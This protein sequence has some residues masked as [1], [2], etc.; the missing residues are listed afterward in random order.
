MVTAPLERQVVL[1]EDTE[2]NVD[3]LSLYNEDAVV[4]RC[5]QGEQTL[6]QA[7]GPLRG[8]EGYG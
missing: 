2:R 4:G 8:Q 5:P 7:G 3:F 6:L 1:A